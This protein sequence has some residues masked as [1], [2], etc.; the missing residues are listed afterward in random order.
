MRISYIPLKLIQ[1]LFR[2][3]RG[4]A[5]AVVVAFAFLLSLAAKAGL[6]GIPPALLVISWFFKYAYILFDHSVRGFDEPT[7][8]DTEMM[9][10]LSEKRPLAQVALLGLIGYAVYLTREHFG[11][12]AALALGIVCGFFVPASVAIL[13]LESNIL[14][15]ANPLYWL[16][17][18]RGLG[19]LY[20]AVLLVILAYALGLGLLWK[21]DLWPPVEIAIGMFSV[22]SVFHFL[23]VF[24]STPPHQLH[25]YTRSHPP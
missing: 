9:N 16:N 19:L 21:F 1:P 10:P 24:S 11:Y 12:P 15:A 23:G 18:V 25:F 14:K 22:L 20:G 4:G 5:A 17:L 13:G 7:V 8:I 6:M 3:A 2:P